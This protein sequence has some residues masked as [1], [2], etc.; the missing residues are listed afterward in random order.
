MAFAVENI[1]NERLTNVD[2][3]SKT[4]T[5][6]AFIKWWNTVLSVHLLNRNEKE[7]ENG[8]IKK[9]EM[10]VPKIRFRHCHDFYV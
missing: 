2:Y 9:P 6:E 3:I 10:Y 7:G 4:P 1:K 5:S 8:E